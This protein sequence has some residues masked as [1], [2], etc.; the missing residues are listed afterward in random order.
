MNIDLTEHPAIAT[1]REE[2]TLLSL[3]NT[4]VTEEVA[5]PI[6]A[7]PCGDDNCGIRDTLDRLGD[8]WTVLVL[9]ELRKGTRRFG[10]LQR[11]LPGISQ[12]MLTLTTK[13]LWRD[14]FLERTAYPTIPP[15]VE[16][17]LTE[18]GES[19]AE[20][21]F[22]LAEWSRAHM[23]GVAAARARWDAEHGGLD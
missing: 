14:G 17:R 3:T 6:P 8:K 16:Y 20:V 5:D 22:Y 9:A 2:G 12:R 19:L 11:A 21:A 4:V 7:G 1:A 15:Q 18:S 13:R 10:E 23:D